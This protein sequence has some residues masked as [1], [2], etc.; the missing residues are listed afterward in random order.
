MSQARA[1][2]VLGTGS[3]VGKSLLTA[4]LCRIFAQS[5]Y[6]VAPFKSQNMSLNSAATIEGLE[7]GRAQ[8]LQAEAAG[9][10]ASVHM[11]PILIKPSGDCTSQVVVRGKIWGQISAADYHQRRVEE[12]MPMVRESFQTL[13]S[14]YQVIVLEGA[15]SPAEIN[16]KQHDIANM[17]MADMADAACLLV[18]DIDRGGVFASLLGTVE[19]LDPAERARIRGFCINKFRGDLSLLQPGVHMMEERLRKPCLGVV[20]YLPGLSLEEEDSVGLP[21]LARTGWEAIDKSHN[22]RL[23]I[24]VVALPSFSNFTDFDSLRAEPSVDL[25]LCR[26][27]QLLANADVVVL[28]GSKETMSDLE[29]MLA[30]GFDQALRLFPGLIMGICGG[31]QMLGREIADPAGIERQGCLP[32]LDLLPI[33]TTMQTDKVTRLSS[34]TIQHTSLFQQQLRQRQ[35]AGYEIHVGKT[36]YLDQ[37]EPFATLENGELDGC[38]SIDR[39]VLGTYLHGIFDDDSFRHEFLHAAR[40]FHRLA[41]PSVLNP[42]RAQREESLDRL[43][44]QVSTS[45]DMRQIFSWAG[46]DYE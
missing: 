30:G 41:S 19:L 26:S 7:I 18:G 29:W 43:A 16:L 45:L 4:A 21:P 24:A 25:L 8:A 9:I 1:I 28:P 33:S 39:R 37:A 40:S 10:A 44:S 46:L 5:G 3:H 34:G 12:L 27:A 22:R 38:I 36:S 31:M 14:K 23:R 13:A 6:S 20:P 42:W 35:V 15:G 2:M 32:G 11:N 17:R